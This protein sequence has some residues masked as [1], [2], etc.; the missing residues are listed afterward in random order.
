VTKQVV[1]VLVAVGLAALAGGQDSVRDTVHNLSATGPGTV[2]ALSESRVCVFCH[3]PHNAA[4]QAP[5]WNRED[6]GGRFEMYWSETMDAYTSAAAAPQ[7]NG[8]SKLCL[9]C[10]DGTIALGST[11]ATGNIPMTGGITTLPSSSEAYLGRDLSGDHPVSFRVTDNLIAANNSKGDVPLRSL[12]EMQAH[13]EVRLDS[14][15]R[16]QCTTCHDPHRDPYGDF[17]VVADTGEL[18]LAC[19][20]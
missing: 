17:L 6:P 13:P 20:S 4:T 3:T 10:H 11:V 9:S 2:R 1:S 18:C 15:S 8:A 12:T 5:L 19:H 7:P 16:L 14:E